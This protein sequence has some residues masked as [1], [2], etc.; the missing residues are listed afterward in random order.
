VIEPIS[1]IFFFF[2]AGAFMNS[3]TNAQSASDSQGQQDRFSPEWLKNKL[4]D[5]LKNSPA[6][7]LERNVRAFMNQSAQ[8]MG[9]VTREEFEVR[10]EII[11]RL[12]SR[13]TA[14][15]AELEKQ[16]K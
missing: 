9:F 8:Q 15:E 12:A 11:D 16:R 4:S 1:K 14:L 2:Y 13:V 3:D 6:A 5:L 10:I 7:D